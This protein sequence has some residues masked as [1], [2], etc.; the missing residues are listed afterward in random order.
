MDEK[1]LEQEL[2]EIADKLLALS[3]SASKVSNACAD[4][5]DRLTCQE[6]SDKLFKIQSDIRYLPYTVAYLEL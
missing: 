3:L 6:L 1:K 2:T 5:E 4:S